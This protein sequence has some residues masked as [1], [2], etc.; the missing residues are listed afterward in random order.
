M[1]SGAVV[2]GGVGGAQSGVGWERCGRRLYMS[3]SAVLLFN[4]VQTSTYKAF[5]QL[6]PFKDRPSFLV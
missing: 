2:R 6:E 4:N 1:R 3:F 5:E